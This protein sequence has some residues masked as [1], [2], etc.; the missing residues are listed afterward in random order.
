LVGGWEMKGQELM[1][2][3]TSDFDELEW[4]SEFD[5]KRET[6]VNQHVQRHQA[7]AAN[8]ANLDRAIAALSRYIVK[9]NGTYQFALP[10][11]SISEV[12]SKLGL[13]PGK[14]NLL[15]NSLRQRNARF[16]PALKTQ[17]EMEMEEATCP[18]RKDFREE[19]WGQRYWLNEC[20]TQAI[21]AILDRDVDK[22]GSYLC[23]ALK[24]LMEFG[25]DGLGQAASRVFD[26]LCDALVAYLVK[27]SAGGLGRIDDDGGN[28]GVVVNIV[29]RGAGEPWYREYLPRVSIDSQ[30]PYR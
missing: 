28:Q 14:V 26:S 23:K 16:Q 21:I 3:A 25:T 18:G 17:E 10:A 9:R 27:L 22:G 15:L 19:W 30:A 13:A 24:A 4:L 12:A 7:H 29:R 5:D 6:A 2:A 8:L 20:Q 1:N 11:G